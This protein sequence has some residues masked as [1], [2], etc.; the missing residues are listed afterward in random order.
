MSDLSD[1]LTDRAV[2]AD[3]VAANKKG[4]FQQLAAAASRLSGVPAKAIAASL[5]AREKIGS[6]GFGGGAAIPHAR[7]DGLS[8][9]FGYFA[10]LPTPVDFQA[11]DNVPVDLVFLL[12]SPLDA[13]ADHLKALAR[14][15]RVFR[16]PQTVAKLR[17]ARSRDAL[18]ALLAGGEARDAA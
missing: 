12:L 4:L 8:G 6:T 14:V 9:V 1:I 7:I 15:S 5:N 13:G 10:R 3:L 16:D 11:I 18:Y 17:G 2:D